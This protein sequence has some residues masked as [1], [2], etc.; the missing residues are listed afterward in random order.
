MFKIVYLVIPPH[1]KLVAPEIPPQSH[2]V[3]LAFSVS[4]QATNCIGVSHYDKL[5]D[6][7]ELASSVTPPRNGLMLT[8]R[9]SAERIESVAEPF[10][11]YVFVVVT[12]EFRDAA[13][14]TVLAPMFDSSTV[15]GP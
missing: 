6:V 7:V 5:V 1:S 4:A 12:F 10:D 2:G 13:T 15:S 3:V 9:R 14:M 8:V 11:W